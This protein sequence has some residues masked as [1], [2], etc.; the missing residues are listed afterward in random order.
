MTNDAAWRSVPGVA[1]LKKLN[2]PHVF[3]AFVSRGTNEGK[4]LF[5]H[6]HADGAYVVS[7]TR[8]ER[9]YIRVHHQSELLTWLEQGYRLRMSNPADG[10]PQ[11][12]LVAPVAI[13]RPIEL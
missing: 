7:M 2:R 4:M 13:Y 8:F 9:D 11:P 1:K 12:S 3:H 5:P 6:K 10:I